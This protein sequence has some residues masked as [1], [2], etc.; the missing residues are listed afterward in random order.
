VKCRPGVGLAA[1]VA[2]GLVVTSSTLDNTLSVYEAL[3]GAGFPLVASFGRK[4]SG[5]LQFDLQ[6]DGQ[7]SGW[8]C[9][10]QPDVPGAKPTLL[11]AEAGNDRVQEVDVVGRAHVGFLA[12]RG[13]VQGPRAVD[14][15]PSFIAVS[16]WRARDSGPHVVHLFDATSRAQLR[17]LGGEAGDGPGRLHRPVGLCI[18]ADQG[19]VAVVDHMNDRVCLFTTATGVYRRDIATLPDHGVVGP[20]DVAQCLGGWLVTGGSDTVV[21]V[22]TDGGGDCVQELGECGDEEGQFRG[23]CALALLPS[24]GLVVRQLGNSKFQVFAVEG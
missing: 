1:S 24:L 23:P 7:A 10:T 9:F 16:A 4:G 19:M 22:P 8:M 5:P 13:S 15:S 20:W 17:V 6:A 12:D 2:L 3:P 18:N 14:A 21:R 11:V